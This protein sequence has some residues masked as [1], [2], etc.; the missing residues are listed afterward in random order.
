MKYHWNY[1]SLT[2][3][4]IVAAM[5]ITVANTLSNVPIFNSLPPIH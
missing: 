1:L 5:V 3:S 4:E 2:L